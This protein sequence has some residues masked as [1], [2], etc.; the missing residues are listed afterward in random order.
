VR[1]DACGNN[2]P[3]VGVVAPFGPSFPFGQSVMLAGQITDEDTQFPVERLVFTSDRQGLIPGTRTAGGR[4]LFTTALV[5]GNHRVTLTVTDSGG[6]AGQ[7]SLDISILNRPPDVP[8]IIQ[9]GANANLAAGSPILLRG[10]GFDPDSG[11]LPPSALSWSAQ[12]TPGGPFVALGSGN[13]LTHVFAT[14]ADPVLIR[15]T[16]SDST[17]QQAHAERQVKIVT[18]T[19]NAA[20][21]VAIRQPDPLSQNGLLVGG[22]QAGLQTHFLGDAWDVEDTPSDLQLRWEFTAIESLGGPPDPTPAVPNPAPVTGTLAPAV[23]FPVGGP[24][25]LYRVT[26]TATDSGGLSNS[27]SVEIYVIPGP[28]L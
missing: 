14:P 2:P 25:Q 8:K 4:T 15:L 12:L 26:F 3:Q 9:P 16:A 13:E 28:I 17:A 10:T 5:P 21:N 27:E 6:L 24:E 20:P 23:V 19:G 18:G 11:Q 22:A 1:K 7:G